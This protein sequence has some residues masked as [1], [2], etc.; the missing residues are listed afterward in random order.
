MVLFYFELISV[1]LLILVGYVACPFSL[2]KYTFLNIFPFVDLVICSKVF[3]SFET[4]KQELVI[5]LCTQKGLLFLASLSVPFFVT[6]FLLF[7]MRRQGQMR[8][9]AFISSFLGAFL[10]GGSAVFLF[11]MDL[12]NNSRAENIPFFVG[13]TTIV[14][15][16]IQGLFCLEDLLVDLREKLTRPVFYPQQSEM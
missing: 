10:V 1:V 9:I 14:F 11:I 7:L 13:G 5:D 16:I 8:N 15:I 4:C 12:Q 2:V 3:L 6:G